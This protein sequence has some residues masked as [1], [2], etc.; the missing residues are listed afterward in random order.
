MAIR[1]NLAWVRPVL[2]THVPYEATE[3]LR[4]YYRPR[5]PLSDEAQ[6]RMTEIGERLQA[7]EEEIDE[8][9]DQATVNALE[10]ENA[11]LESEYDELS[12]RAHYIPE[13]DRP[14]VGTFLLINAQGEPVLSPRSEARREGK[15]CVGT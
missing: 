6:A 7:I 11:G 5:V 10:I 2:A 3:A 1:E 12:N 13:E 8:A 14:N 9:P 15:E 4:D